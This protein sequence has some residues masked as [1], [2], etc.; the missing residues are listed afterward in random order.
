MKRRRQ[1]S[2]AAVGVAVVLLAACAATP[3][4]PVVDRSGPDRES[5]EPATAVALP[6]VPARVPDAREKEPEAPEPRAVP[7]A[8]NPATVALLT[9]AEAEI[10]AG[11]YPIAGAKIDR[12]L[13]IDPKDPWVWHGL[14]T[15][16]LASGELAQAA[17]TA[18]RSNALAGSTDGLHA[19][20]WYLIAEG[21]RLLGNSSASEAALDEAERYAERARLTAERKLSG[22]SP[23]RE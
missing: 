16:Q 3:P 4:A 13:R 6:P 14:A 2:R 10:N 11:R 23:L 20:N 19:R 22:K 9:A 17:A 15:L 7:F 12:A 21:E 5:P 1:F 18:R 8:R